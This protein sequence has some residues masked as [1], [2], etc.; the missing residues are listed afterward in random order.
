[1]LY[2]SVAIRIGEEKVHLWCIAIPEPYVL[3]VEQTQ[4]Q[5]KTNVPWTGL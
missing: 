5:V 3:W 1:M 4:Y 2:L